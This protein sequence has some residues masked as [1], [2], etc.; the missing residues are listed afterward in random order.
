MPAW[1][2]PGSH[3]AFL[4]HMRAWRVRMSWIVLLSAWPRCSAAV[5]FGGG[6]QMENASPGASGSA[7]KASASVHFRPISA[8]FSAGLY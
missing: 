1:S 7:L 8:S 3:T 5:T 2:V 6:M 4:P